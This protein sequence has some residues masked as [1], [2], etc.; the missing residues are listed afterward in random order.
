MHSLSLCVCVHVRVSAQ[1]NV[2]VGG[3]L[4][5]GFGAIDEQLES[6]GVL[7]KLE[8]PPELSEKQS[9]EFLKVWCITVHH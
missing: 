6:V 5:K 9:A 1:F 2:A 8:A 3:A 7:P 4:A